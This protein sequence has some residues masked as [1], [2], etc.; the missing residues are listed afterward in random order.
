MK[1]LLP[2]LLLAA[3]V[4][5]LEP[6]PSEDTSELSVGETRSV[7]LWMLEFNVDGYEQAIDLET[8]RGLPQS[9][10]D[11]TWLL[12]MP[13][14]GLVESSLLQLRDLPIDQALDLPLPAQNMRT[15]LR[16]TPD[17]AELTGTSLE[18]LLSLS[19]VLG[20]PSANTLADLFE[21]EV[22]DNVLP[23]D[24]ASKALVEGLIATHPETQ[25]RQGPIDAE[26]PDGIWA[27]APN[28]MPITAGDVVSNFESMAERFA[29]AQTE[30]GMHPGFIEEASGFSVVDD[31][32]QMIVKVRLN[33][34]P[35]R[36]LDLTN[37]TSA[38][39][40][41][42]GAQIDDMFA[43]EDPEWLRIEGMIEEPY[44]ARLTTVIEESDQFIAGGNTPDPLPYGNSA[45]WDLPPWQF[46]SLV[47]AMAYDAT[48]SLT[49]KEISYE[50]NTGTVI[51]T[52]EMDDTGWVT[53]ETFNN[54]GNPPPPQYVWDHELELAQIR[55]H[56]GGLAEGDGDISF[57]LEDVSVGLTSDEI[58]GL[59]AD[60]LAANPSALR[61]LATAINENSVGTADFYYY[62]PPPTASEAEAGDWLYFIDELD[63]PIVE[64]GGR[65]YTYE[66][67]GF[68]ADKGLTDKVSTT[69]ML[70]GDDVHEKVRVEAGDVLYIEDDQGSLFEI[71]VQTK[72]SLHRVKLD[73]TRL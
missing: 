12:D 60:N 47:A 52:A 45:A 5:P 37:A 63:F 34:L 43:T 58:G 53:F 32:F 25:F 20:I 44:I 64:E 66:L 40:N 33:A 68:Y 50:L 18:E 1:R 49:S 62:R 67:P 65:E 2:C 21:V 4:Q 17:N 22:T 30:F 23:L 8:L 57:T 59:I 3:C 16:M 6:N 9:T 15:M 51:F 11:D 10:L 29:P 14:L 31:E 71:R 55:L 28:S 13:L 38:T 41:S 69:E 7:E 24:S 42:T 27:V 35:Y 36:G 26:H 46:E 48:Q 61:D 72:P 19:A 70:H 54:A 56:D 39:V 73:V